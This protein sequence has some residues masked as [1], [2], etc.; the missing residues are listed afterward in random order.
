MITF[1]I[2]VELSETIF[3]QYSHTSNSRGSVVTTKIVIESQAVTG[4]Q[5]K[6]YAMSS[7]Q[8]WMYNYT[9]N[10]SCILD[11]NRSHLESANN[12]Q[13]KFFSIFILSMGL[14]YF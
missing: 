6:H 13:S 4:Y 7:E 9:Q 3:R 12:T 5:T 14:D 2:V 11:Y 8:H 10:N 1:L